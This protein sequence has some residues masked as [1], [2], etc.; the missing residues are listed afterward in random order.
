MK[1]KLVVIL[2]PT[3]IGKTKLSIKLAKHF[4]SEIISCDSRQFYKELN[5]GTAPPSKAQLRQVRHHFIQDR[6]IKSEFNAGMFENEAINLIESNNN[7]ILFAVGGSGLYIDAICKGLD[8][9]P[10]VPKDIRNKL[11]YE[12]KKNGILWLQKQIKKIDENYEIKYDIN[13]PQRMLRFIEVY[14]FTGKSI[15]YFKMN[16]TKKRNFD[17]I[18]I[19]LFID[20]IKLYKKINSRVDLM[21][22]NGLINEVESLISHKDKNALQTVGYKEIFK[23]FDKEYTLDVAIEKIKQNTRNFAK[24]QITWF[25]KDQE[26]NWFKTVQI[27]EILEFIEAN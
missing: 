14:Y 20:R 11:T 1:K 8:N 21:I 16:K 12:Y 22:K 13:N 23:Y 27:K 9:I 19:G 25:K 26:I 18:K 15:E 17:I 10:I 6:S 24:R 3:A 4:K 5:I 7:K 2:G